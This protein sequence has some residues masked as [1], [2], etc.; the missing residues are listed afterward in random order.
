MGFVKNKKIIFS[1][2]IISTQVIAENVLQEGTHRIYPNFDSA[3]NYSNNKVSNNLDLFKNIY[4]K[5]NLNF[6]LPY[7]QPIIPLKIHQIW[8]GPRPLPEK[9]KWMTKTWEDKN[10]G[11]QYKLWTNEDLKNFN[12]INQNAFDKAQNWGAKSDIFRI[13]ILKRYGGIYIDTDFECLKPLEIL[14]YSYSFY[15]CLIPGEDVAANG[16]IACVPEHPII[17]DYIDQI[18]SEKNFNLINWRDGTEVMKATGPYK[19]TDILINY[20]K[21]NSNQERIIVLPATYFFPF[22]LHLREKYWNNGFSRSEI[23]KC[24]RPES[25]AVHYWATS[26]QN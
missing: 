1:F 13:E 9:F 17:N 26:W 22:D 21:K 8:I 25:F 20:L 16:I 10:P 3:H 15:C 19:F 4:Q 12:L 11:W 7:Y 2:L 24:F 18:K 5:N 6:I 23:E 14:N